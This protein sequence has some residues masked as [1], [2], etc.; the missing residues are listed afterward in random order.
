[1]YFKY[2]CKQ[3]KF[4]AGGSEKHMKVVLALTICE[5]SLSFLWN[6]EKN[7]SSFVER[8]ISLYPYFT[9]MSSRKFC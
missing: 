1:M 5:I 2:K 9:R 8:M 3:K 4:K 7:C 6:N